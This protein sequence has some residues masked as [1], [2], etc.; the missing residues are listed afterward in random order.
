MG[1]EYKDYY[2]IL[3]VGRNADKDAISRAYKKLARQY[4]PDLN[5]GNSSAEE[6]FKEVTEAYEV[7][8]DTEKRKMYDQLGPDWQNAQ[9]FRNG[10]PGFENMHF[11]FNGQHVD[12]AGFSDFFETLFGGARADR[13]G[14]FGADPFNGFSARHQR[15]RDVEAELVIALEDVVKGG[16]RSVTVQSGEGPRTLK[17]TIP[18]GVRDGARLRLAGQGQPS[19]S[20]APDQNGDLYLKIRFA[21]HPRF[22][23]DGNDLI[24]DLRLE[25]WEAV[26]GV[27][28]RVPTLEG[29]VEMSIPA[30]TAS[31]RKL[32][33]RG[34]GLGSGATRGDEYIRV[35]INA[36]ATLTAKQRELWEAL[37]VE[38]RK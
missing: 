21:P 29:E 35:G 20:G 15:G 24:H 26:L 14:G 31:G 19:L 34:K 9:Q 10:G 13:R 2:K 17:V 30:G 27:K 12:G 4:H 8:K 16:E 33:L 11:S 18:P 25:P 22:H 37:A 36:P 7:L 5:P 6:K 38:A 32:R 1:L 23:V 28:V 3:G